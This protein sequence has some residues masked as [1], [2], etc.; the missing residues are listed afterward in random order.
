MKSC[1]PHSPWTPWLFLAPFLALFSAFIAWPLLRSLILAFE[2]T[3]GPRTVTYV[4]LLNFRFM[5]HDPMFWVAVRNTALF[6]FGTLVI[7]VPAALVLA[8]LLNRPA[9]RGRALFRL[10]FFS[11]TIVG[12]VFVGVIFS[13]LLE[14][15]TGLVNTL[16]HGLIRSWNPDF[17]WVDG[18]V[19]PSLILASLWL[20]VGFNM[21]YLLAALQNVPSDQLDAASIDGANAWQRFWHVTVPA[22]QP[23]LNI[24]V[25][26]TLVGSFQL[27]DLPFIL[28]A[29][30]FGNGPNNAALSIVTYLYQ[31]GFRSGDLGYASA[32]GWVLTLVL[33]AAALLHRR[34]SRHEEAGS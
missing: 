1:R 23:V 19:M 28:Y 27:F 17:A 14:R 21:A 8:L 10:V 3:F 30:S 5:L 11:P 24:L 4:G 15:R 18:F 31:T 26:L 13:V 12:T 22:I 2:Q 25:L 34:L 7:Q 33:V 9:L 29:D 32:I 20:S 6:A 16:L